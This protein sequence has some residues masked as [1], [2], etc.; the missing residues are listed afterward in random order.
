VEN[1]ISALFCLL[2]RTKKRRAGAS[3]KATASFVKRSSASPTTRPVRTRGPGHARGSDRATV[4]KRTN[5]RSGKEGYGIELS[6]AEAA[7]RKC[8]AI[9]NCDTH[10][11]HWV[12]DLVLEESDL[13]PH[14]EKRRSAEAA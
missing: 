9:R 3:R 6:A 1:T 13:S 8:S 5:R 7:P 12:V 11:P 4:R 10:C 14:R 2:E